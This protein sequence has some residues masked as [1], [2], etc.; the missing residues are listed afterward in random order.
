MG[1]LSQEFPEVT[2]TLSSRL[3]DADLRLPTKPPVKTNATAAATSAKGKTGG[4]GGVSS[5]Q[6]SFVQPKTFGIGVM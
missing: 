4:G 1:Q 6:G 5:S 3:R 2:D